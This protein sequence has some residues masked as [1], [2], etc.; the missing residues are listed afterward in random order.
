MKTASK[1]DFKIGAKL[2]CKTEGWEFTI[3]RNYDD[4]VWEARGEAGD[5]CVFECEASCYYVK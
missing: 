1:Q 3:L 5:K 2:V 4:G